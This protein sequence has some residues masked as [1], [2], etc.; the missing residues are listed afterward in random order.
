MSLIK[1]IEFVDVDCT[2]YF[3]INGSSFDKKTIFL[4]P[5]TGYSI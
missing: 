2:E 3:A 1:S 5:N 4:I